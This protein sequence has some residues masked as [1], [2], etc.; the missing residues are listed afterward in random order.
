MEDM[1]LNGD[2]RSKIK[3]LVS[4]LFNDRIFDINFIEHLDLITD[5]GMDSLTFISMIIEIEVQFNITVSD[6]LLFME[7]F[8]NIND[9]VE[10]IENEI[11]IIERLE[12][13]YKS[14]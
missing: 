14:A 8:A 1:T 6:N 12:E 10:I 7:N 2:V 13:D 5:L 3:N 4:G 9:I 11:L